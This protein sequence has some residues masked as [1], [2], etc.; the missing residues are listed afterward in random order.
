VNNKLED[1]SRKIVFICCITSAL[2]PKN[3]SSF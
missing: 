1:I 3:W 2:T